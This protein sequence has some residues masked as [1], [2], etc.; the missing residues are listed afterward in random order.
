[1]CRLEP[2][3]DFTEEIKAH[4]LKYPNAYNIPNN[5]TTISHFQL[6]KEDNLFEILDSNNNVIGFVLLYIEFL[7]NAY[8]PGEAEIQVGIF[9]KN[10]MLPKVLPIIVNQFNNYNFKAIIKYT[11]ASKAKSYISNILLEAKFTDQT[12][13]YYD[14]SETE[15]NL[16]YH[17]DC[18]K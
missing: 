13:C 11:N 14:A 2:I 18:Q 10:K 7:P 15:R 6:S 1:M 16:I 5:D 8:N 12:N 3:N 17:Y 4:I 9:N